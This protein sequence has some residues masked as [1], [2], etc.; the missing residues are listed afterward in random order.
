MNVRNEMICF[1]DS[2]NIDSFLPLV[3]DWNQLRVEPSWFRYAKASMIEI[4][5]RG[6]PS[7]G[8]SRTVYPTGTTGLGKSRSIHSTGTTGPDISP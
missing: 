5:D 1:L 4:R 7:L 8:K 3:W 2:K 6:H